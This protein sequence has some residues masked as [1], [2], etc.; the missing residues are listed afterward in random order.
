MD[1]EDLSA[2]VEDLETMI[3]HQ[4][5]T[6]D[7]LSDELARVNR[8]LERFEKTLVAVADRLGAMEDV[9]LPRPEARK[10]PHY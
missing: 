10:P 3:A 7:E 6:I 2:R 1:R 4:A 9:A 8:R 5:R